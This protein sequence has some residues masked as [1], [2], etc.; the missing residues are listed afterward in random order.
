MIWRRVVLLGLLTVS[1]LAL[2][3]SVLGTVTLTGAKPEL[4][5]LVTV[6]LAMGEGPALGATAGFAA[7]LATDL[8][9]D[10]PHGLGALTFTLVGYGVGRIRAQ[11]QAPSAW[12]PMAMVSVATF[13]GVCFYGGLSFVLGQE[14]LSAAR[15]FRHAGLAAAYNAL[16]TPFAFPL[17]R[18]LAARL[19]PAGVLR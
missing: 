3:T 8:V 4:L 9:L 7:G 6:A 12:L 1:G 13:L 2:E 15:V 17:V 5:L 19:R 18:A 14:S 11:V 16:L 10:L